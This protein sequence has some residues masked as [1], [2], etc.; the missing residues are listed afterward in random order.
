MFS[1]LFEQIVIC[2]V[3]ISLVVNK[4]SVIFKLLQNSKYELD[5]VP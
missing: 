2:K 4:I 5:L 3:T 1:W